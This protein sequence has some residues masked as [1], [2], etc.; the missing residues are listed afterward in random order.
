M[1]QNPEFLGTYV[2]ESHEGAAQNLRQAI[3][4]YIPQDTPCEY[5]RDIGVVQC[6]GVCAEDV[7]DGIMCPETDFWRNKRALSRIESQVPLVWAF[8][9][10]VLARGN[11][12]LDKEMFYNH[13]LVPF[14]VAERKY[15]LHT[16]WR[17]Q[18]LC[19]VRAWH[20]PTLRELKFQSLIME[21]G[22]VLPQYNGAIMLISM[23]VSIAILGKFAF[24]G[25][26]PAWGAA[27]CVA[28]VATYLF[29][30]AKSI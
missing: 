10:P 6:S 4:D 13:L 2:R 18:I 11:D 22:L 17:S 7:W 15:G 16:D 1:K 9:E 26:E 25:W 12:L 20:L 19:L 14:Y 24:G 29:Y 30:C 3:A 5:S 27:A 28:Q 21:E 23:V 8:K